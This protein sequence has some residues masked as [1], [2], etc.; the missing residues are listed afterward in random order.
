MNGNGYIPQYRVQLKE[1][2]SW[3]T[4][5]FARHDIQ[6]ST[7]IV[8]DYFDP[9]A[10][11]GLAAEMLSSFGSVM[12]NLFLIIL[13]VIFMLFEAFSFPHKLHFALDD[14]QMRL[15]PLGFY[16]PPLAA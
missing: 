13:T 12:E 10:A 7:S 1:K 16:S 5:F 4:D 9:A 3:L 15:N 2:F 6:L 14:P 8:T 11:M